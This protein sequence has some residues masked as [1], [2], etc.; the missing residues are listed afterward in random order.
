MF[1]YKQPEFLERLPKGTY[2]L[3]TLAEAGFVS[4]RTMRRWLKDMNLA[5]LQTKYTTKKKYAEFA[6]ESEK[7]LEIYWPGINMYK[8]LILKQEIKKVKKNVDVEEFIAEQKEKKKEEK[9]KAKK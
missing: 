1:E 8:Y 7:E 3:Q 2:T 6:N 9:K 4:L 5:V